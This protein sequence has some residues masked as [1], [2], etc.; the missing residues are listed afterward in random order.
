M[1]LKITLTVDP[2]RGEALIGLLAKALGR[3]EAGVGDMRIELI[4]EPVMREARQ[5]TI[6]KMVARA[7][8]PKP[9]L[10]YRKRE[11]YSLG[12]RAIRSGKANGVIITLKGLA[13]D[14]SREGLLE[15]WDAANLNRNGMSATLS[16]MKKRGLTT[17]LGEGVWRMTQEGKDLLDRWEQRHEKVE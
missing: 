12:M 8:L 11:G 1:N 3:E 4:R 7:N 17:M 2:E 13:M 10:P 15:L 5:S 14:A 16:K 9:K 6:A